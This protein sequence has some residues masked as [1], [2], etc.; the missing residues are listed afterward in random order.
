LS[1]SL[2]AEYSDYSHNLLVLFVNHF[3][4][5]YGRDKIT[6]NV[7]V[8]FICIMMLNYMVCLT[9]CLHFLLEITWEKLRE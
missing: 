8:W 4:D 7:Q 2:C 5:L 6:Y 1:P 9:K 3:G